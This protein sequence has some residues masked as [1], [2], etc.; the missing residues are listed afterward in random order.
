MVS[1][2][3]SVRLWSN[4]TALKLMKETSPDT[5]SDSSDS[6]SASLLLSQYGLSTTESDSDTDSG[7][8]TLADYLASQDDAGVSEDETVKQPDS[9]TSED[10]MAFLKQQLEAM[11]KDPSKA[12]QATAML[13]ALENGTLTVTDVT[14]GKTVTALNSSSASNTTVQA[15][16]INQQDWGTF[17]RDHL[18]RQNGGQFMRNEDGSYVDRA[19][20]DSAYFG[21]LGDKSYYLTWTKASA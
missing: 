16:D 11:T 1:T 8:Y 14:E 6:S 20:G 2:V 17:L 9:L 21:S 12:E 10:F 5:S 18:S 4:Q 13:Q 19:T 15:E 7:T 3:D